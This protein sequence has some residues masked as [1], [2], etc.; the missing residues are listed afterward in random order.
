MKTLVTGCAGM[1]GTKLVEMLINSDMPIVGCDNFFRGTRD[2]IDFLKKQSNKKGVDFEFHEVDLLNGLPASI[3]EGVDTVVHLADVVGGI[4]YV[5]DNQ[6]DVFNLNVTIDANTVRAIADSKVKKYIYAATACSF[7]HQLQNSVDSMLYEKDKFPADPESPYGWS[8]LVGELQSI[9]LNKIDGIESARVIFH[10]VYGPWC[11]FDLDT[12]QVIPALINKAYNLKN[13]ERLEV[14]GDGKQARSFI[15]SYDIANSLLVMI[16]G[17]KPLNE[18]DSIQLGDEVGTTI[19]ELSKI[20]LS[21]LG[22]DQSLIKYINPDY[23]GDV[24]RIPDLALA[25]KLGIKQ[26]VGI[27]DGIRELIEWA[28]D[29]GKV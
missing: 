2:N 12:S 29:N 7:P 25:K 13:G 10:N 17:N 27:R 5:F 8:K 3:L 1:I 11:D 16:K 18:Y 23:R 14:W 9:Y 26:K 19:E 28:E 24:G 21:E 4:K 20:I 15:N 6:L 22:K